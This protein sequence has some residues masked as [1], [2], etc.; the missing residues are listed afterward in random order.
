MVKPKI[1]L[2]QVTIKQCRNIMEQIK[3]ASRAGYYGVDLDYLDI[4]EYLEKGKNISSLINVLHQNKLMVS[5][6]ASFRGWQFTGGIPL[7]P[8]KEKLVNQEEIIKEARKFLKVCSDLDCQYVLAVSPLK[9]ETGSIEEAANDLIRVCDLAGEFGRSVAFEFLGF[10]KQINN[11]LI[12]EEIVDKSGCKNV[13][14][15]LDTFHFYVGGSQVQDLEKVP[16]EHIALVHIN[17]AKNKPH[18]LLRDTE[19][20]VYPGDGIIPLEKILKILKDKGYYG[21]Y[22]IEI[23]NEEYWKE[24]P[25]KIATLAREKTEKILSKI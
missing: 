8:S 6:L 2:Q 4:K 13:G 10:S 16:L 15:L 22:S 18:N 5:H 21:C 24:D 1:T 14:I 11:I 17:D 9:E 23:F 25:L 19:D 7:I 3:I 12:A 20:R